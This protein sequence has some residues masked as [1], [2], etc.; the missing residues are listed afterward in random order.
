ML[1]VIAVAYMLFG[2]NALSQ[3][4]I[5]FVNFR[6]AISGIGA[7]PNYLEIG[8]TSELGIVAAAMPA[9][10]GFLLFRL[11]PTLSATIHGRQNVA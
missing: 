7:I 11:A 3:A 1:S 10:W 5:A 9:L 6:Q 8:R 2:V 4:I